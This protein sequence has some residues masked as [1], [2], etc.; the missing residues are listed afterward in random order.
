[1]TRLIWSCDRYSDAECEHEEIERES[2]NSLTII[3]DFE[4]R[5]IFVQMKK[6]F[7]K[8]LYKRWK[9]KI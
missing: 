6:L 3:G 8:V 9:T 1:M 4:L 7:K 2:V 5:V